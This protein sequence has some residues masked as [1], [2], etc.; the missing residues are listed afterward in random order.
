MIP[1]ARGDIRLDDFRPVYS[2]MFAV[3]FVVELLA[4]SAERRYA[5]DAKATATTR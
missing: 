5:G 2:G 4:E 1:F 3:G